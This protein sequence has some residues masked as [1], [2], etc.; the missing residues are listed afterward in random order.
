LINSGKSS[1]EIARTIGVDRHTVY[2]WR[3]TLIEGGVRL[4]CGIDTPNEVVSFL[5]EIKLILSD[6]DNN[7]GQFSEHVRLSNGQ[8][9]EYQFSWAT[10]MG[11][12]KISGEYQSKLGDL[13]G[14]VAVLHPYKRTRLCKLSIECKIALP[15]DKPPK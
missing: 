10:G 1:A 12:L 2:R 6:A 9:G 13:P 15:T 5:D 3:K 4:L 14:W 11:W 7:S 8:N